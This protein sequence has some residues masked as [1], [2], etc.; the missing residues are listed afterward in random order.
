MSKIEYITQKKPHK[1]V[2]HD[3]VMFRPFV[4]FEWPLSRDFQLEEA[5]NYH[6][7]TRHPWLS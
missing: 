7:P 4:T 2:L 1:V 3:M 5:K 6:I